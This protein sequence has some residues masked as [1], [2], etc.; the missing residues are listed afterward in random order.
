M[1]GD[2]PSL[3]PTRR[4]SDRV[5]YY[6]RSR[7]RYPAAILDFCQAEL[8]LKTTDPVADVGSGTGFL[9]ELFLRNGNEVFCVEP[10]EPMRRAAEKSLG[11]RANF[12]SVA[13]TAEETGL[14]SGHFGFVIAGQAF[15]WFD[16]DRAKREFGRILRA[17][18]WVLL[19]WN[20]REKQDTSGGFAAA[21]DAMVREFQTDWDKVRHESITSQDSKALGDFFA[22]AGFKLKTFN[23]PQSLDL[24]GLIARTLSS[25]Y[26]PL[27]GQGRCEEM[28]DRVREIFRVYSREGRVVQQYTTKVYYGQLK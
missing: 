10:N 8:N 2:L 24:D 19:I 5:E 27:P 28:L 6:V 9:S 18:G 25:S 21:Y 4:F 23:N 26:L 17:G 22:P 1:G 3:D 11:D 12:H 20:E 16:R 14:A 7:P 13:A 15:H